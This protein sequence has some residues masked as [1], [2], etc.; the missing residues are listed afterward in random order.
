MAFEFGRRRRSRKGSR[1]S[2]RPRRSRR[3]S[4]RSVEVR[5]SRRRSRRSSGR[6]GGKKSVLKKV[7]AIKWGQGVSLGDA[8]KIYRGEK[9]GGRKR[10]R[11]GFGLV[12]VPGF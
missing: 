12:K 11:K 4:R 8:W 2:R 10:S 1:R 9:T 3:G 5:V 6:K 7:M